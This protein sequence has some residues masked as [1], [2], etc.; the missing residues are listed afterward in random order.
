MGEHNARLSVNVNSLSRAHLIVSQFLLLEPEFS[1][2]F[3]PDAEQLVPIGR[4]RATNKEE[5]DPAQTR[6]PKIAQTMRWQVIVVIMVAWKKAMSLNVH[7]RR[8][9]TVG[10]RVSHIADLHRVGSVI[11]D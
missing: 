10:L 9:L 5:I 11:P 1:A 3:S 7:V 2:E 4:L 6:C 8:Q